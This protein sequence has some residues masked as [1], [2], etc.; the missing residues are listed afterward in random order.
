VK[1]I[2]LIDNY[3]SFVHNLARYMRRLGVETRVVRND[4]IQV[5]QIR[6]LRPQAVV[7]SPGPCTPLEAG[8]SLSVVRELAGEIP[9]LGV[10]LGHQAIA[11]AFG[12]KIVRAPQP[13]HGRASRITHD[14]RRLF[15]N[16]PSPLTVGRYHS[17]VIDQASLPTELQVTARAS[18]GVIMAIEHRSQ[19]IWGVQFHPESILSVG[20]FTLLANFLTMAGLQIE[21]LP[22]MAGEHPPSIDD[23]V[24]PTR[25]VTF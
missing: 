4:D 17:L 25:P 11:A 18:D 7:I 12:G 21:R 8:C 6:E 19:P 22:D 9:L 23:Y 2:L 1:M 14:E 20:G 13:M 10:C 24:L 15:A 16:L 5:Q 3:D